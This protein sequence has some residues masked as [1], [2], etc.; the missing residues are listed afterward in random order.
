MLFDHRRANDELGV[1]IFWV[2]PDM[3]L[4]EPLELFL[5]HWVLKRDGRRRGLVEIRP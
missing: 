5:A 4:G 1:S 3:L 2:R